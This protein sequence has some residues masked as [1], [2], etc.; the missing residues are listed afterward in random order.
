M[1]NAL[2]LF[3][4]LLVAGCGPAA[5]A[6][7]VPA[8]AIPWGA[9]DRAEYSLTVAGQA[10]GTLVFT[11]APGTGG[12]YVLTTETTAGAVKDVSKVRVDGS[13]VPLGATR[14]VTGA[15]ASDFSLMT[16]YDGKSIIGDFPSAAG[17]KDFSPMAIGPYGPESFNISASGSSVRVI[18]L[19]PDQILTRSLTADVS[20]VNGLAV[21]DTERDM[22]KIAVVERHRGTGNIGLGFAHG[23]GLKAGAL[24]SSVAHDSHNIVCIGCSDADMYRA[25]KTVEEMR[26][27]L[28]AVR[29]GRVVDRLA[30][31]IGGLMSDRPLHHVAEGWRKMRRAASD[32]GCT[33][34][35]PFMALSFMAL[36]VM[37]ELKI[38]DRGLVDVDKFEKVSLYVD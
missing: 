3:L 4:A 29:D 31:P 38:T 22:I 27:G 23:F 36:P 9:G 16:V 12:G 33:L 28:A 17:L 37:P 25:V 13:L 8:L 32:L 35:E 19:V 11:T 18:G 6:T 5:T 20:S 30:L 26:G 14:E 15:G 21:S 34:E 1:R 7:P 2:L 10:A 24:A